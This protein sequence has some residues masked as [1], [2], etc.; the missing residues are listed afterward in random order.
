MSFHL[1]PKPGYTLIEI[2]VVVVIMGILLTVVLANYGRGKDDSILQREMS[3][4]IGRLRLAQEQTA[5][6]KEVRY[7]EIFHGSSCKIDTN[8]PLCL[9]DDLTTQHQCNKAITPP[10]G[11][12]ATFSC[13]NALYKQAS[14][15]GE[16]KHPNLS[17]D[18]Y[19]HYYVFADTDKR[20]IYADYG[21]KVE[22]DDPTV[23]DCF[24]VSRQNFAEDT[25]LNAKDS[26]GTDSIV[27]Y[28]GKHGL[29][30]GDTLIADYTLDEKVTIY[31][32]FIK[33]ETEVQ[34]YS[35]QGTK[36][37]SPWTTSVSPKPIVPIINGTVSGN[38]PLQASVQFVPPYGRSVKITDNIYTKAPFDAFG[39]DNGNEWAEMGVMLKLKN[40]DYDCRA[41]TIT[42]AGAITQSVDPNCKFD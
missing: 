11:Y 29:Y 3:L 2:M 1:R 25:E 19:T 24:E 39:G 10:G 38:F 5:A 12:I 26:D 8:D 14:D 28:V 17:E 33:A 42:K 41:V 22:C 35:C 4:L 7:C 31:D 16:P 20:T 9:E 27:S 37:V 18:A 40:R 34:I 6:G 36:K 15:I 30:H 21:T 32:V 13:G 23:T